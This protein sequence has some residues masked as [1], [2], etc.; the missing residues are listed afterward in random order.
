[1]L[2]TI[3]SPSTRQHEK[4]NLQAY[5]KQLHLKPATLLHLQEVLDTTDITAAAAI[6][7]IVAA[8]K[9]PRI[10]NISKEWGWQE[11]RLIVIDCFRPHLVEWLR[12]ALEALLAWHLLSMSDALLDRAVEVGA[13]LLFLVMSA[14][15]VYF[16][17]R[18]R[19]KRL[20]PLRAH[21]S[22]CLPVPIR[23]GRQVKG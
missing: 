9:Q 3:S 8:E 6:T 16:T 10:V 13:A 12:L 23:S 7:E 15:A 19:R 18:V 20:T 2:R 22:M 1:M 17:C 11:L 4:E 21:R 5:W 14:C